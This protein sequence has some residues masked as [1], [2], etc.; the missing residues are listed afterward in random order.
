MRFFLYCC[1][2]FSIGVSFWGAGLTPNTGFQDCSFTFVYIP[3]SQHGVYYYLVLGSMV[4]AS[5][6]YRGGLELGGRRIR[7]RAF[8]QLVFVCSSLCVTHNCSC[9]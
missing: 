4:D 1:V 6:L 3:Y 8:L 2:A 7:E 9:N 5:R